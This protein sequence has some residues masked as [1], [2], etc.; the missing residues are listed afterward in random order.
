MFIYIYI[1]TLKQNSMQK[2][3]CSASARMQACLF[4][5]DDRSGPAWFCGW[6]F[7]GPACMRILRASGYISM[8]FKSPSIDGRSASSRFG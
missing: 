5:L 2:V 8:F 4:P 1:H 6:K 7:C 3:Q